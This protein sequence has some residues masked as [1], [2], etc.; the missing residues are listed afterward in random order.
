MMMYIINT[1][2]GR[3]TMSTFSQCNCL[4]LYG[5][6]GGDSGVVTF[7]SNARILEEYSTVHSQL[8]LFFFF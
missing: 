4:L 7:S 5:G 3:V 8:A 6:G 2:Q 1:Y